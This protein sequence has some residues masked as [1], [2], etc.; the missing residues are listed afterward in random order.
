MGIK[1]ISISRTIGSGAEEIGRLV[2]AGLKF[3]YVDNEIID[4]AAEKAGVSREVIERVERTPPLIERILQHL[5]NAPVESGAY[6]PAYGAWSTTYEGLIE[7]VIHETATAGNVV[8][9][10]H[11][12]SIPLAGMPSALR[13]LVSASPGV[14]AKRIADSADIGIRRAEKAVRDSDRERASFLMRLYSVRHE[15]PTHYDLVINTDLFTTS[16]AADLILKAAKG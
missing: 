15:Q 10:A 11:G 2:A 4:W 1:V 3:R 6:L 14:R 7:R 9:V 12:A 8:I 16:V 5:G 13:V